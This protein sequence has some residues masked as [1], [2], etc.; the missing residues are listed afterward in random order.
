MWFN[1]NNFSPEVVHDVTMTFSCKK[2]LVVIG[3]CGVFASNISIG[4]LLLST[5]FIRLGLLRC[6]TLNTIIPL[7]IGILRNATQRNYLRL[8]NANNFSIWCSQ[9]SLNLN[10]LYFKYYYNVIFISAALRCVVQ[11]TNSR[12]TAK[13]TIES[14][15]IFVHWSE[16]SA[17]DETS[18]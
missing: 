1:E 3:R 9:C 4:H 6:V 12:I 2:W 18:L 8:K 7:G 5:A 16:D 15:H 11:N 14:L 13:K 17:W 10:C